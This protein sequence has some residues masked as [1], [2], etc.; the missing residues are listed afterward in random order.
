MQ[1]VGYEVV[2]YDCVS[3]ERAQQSSVRV[4][5]VENMES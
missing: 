1:T 3:P 4:R 2:R 5:I